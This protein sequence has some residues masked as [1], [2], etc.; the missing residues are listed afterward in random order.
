MASQT[1]ATDATATVTLRLGRDADCDAL[2]ELHAPNYWQRFLE[3]HG[4]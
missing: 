3:V 4:R 1:I 2:R